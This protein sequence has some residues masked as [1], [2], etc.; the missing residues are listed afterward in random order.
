MILRP[1]ILK[2]TM[3]GR[4]VRFKWLGSN[5]AGCS[6]SLVI[7]DW[8][9]GRN[10]CINSIQNR[11]VLSG[12]PDIDKSGN[13]LLLFL[14]LTFQNMIPKLNGN[15]GDGLLPTDTV[16][17][18]T[19]LDAVGHIFRWHPCFDEVIAHLLD[20]V[21]RHVLNFSK[22]CRSKLTALNQLPLQNAIAK[23]AKIAM[24]DHITSID[25]SICFLRFQKACKRRRGQQDGK[26]P[27]RDKRLL[28][29]LPLI[30]DFRYLFDK[31]FSQIFF[32]R[33]G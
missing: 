11:N 12:Q 16:L 24:T 27:S 22:D 19:I 31:C 17:I 13:G 3:K 7:P 6:K 33:L 21:G 32:L 1:G 14:V 18:G 5:D 23:T 25:S 8:P 30:L 10:A 2:L 29:Q 15:D 4:Q 28:Q 20:V 9:G 26:I